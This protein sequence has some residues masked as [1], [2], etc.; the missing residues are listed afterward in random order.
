M[1]NPD[2]RFGFY[3]NQFYPPERYLGKDALPSG[4]TQK[5]HRNFSKGYYFYPIEDFTD[6]DDIFWYR[7]HEISE[8]SL[9]QDIICVK[10]SISQG[11]IKGY[12]TSI[13]SSDKITIRVTHN[14]IGNK[15]IEDKDER[16]IETDLNMKK[17]IAIYIYEDDYPK[18]MK[19]FI[20]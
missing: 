6:E 16:S 1:N 13:E 3:D 15:W 20:N 5:V 7:P 19:G 11:S 14:R 9:D 10:L 8:L 2:E 12:I 17:G 4:M 18:Y